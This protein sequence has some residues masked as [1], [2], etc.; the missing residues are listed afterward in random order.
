[1]TAGAPLRCSLSPK[2]TSADMP[3]A[4]SNGYFARFIRI[5]AVAAVLGGALVTLRGERRA[6]A[7]SG[8]EVSIADLTTF[9]PGVLGD[10]AL[11]G[12]YYEPFVA[13]FGGYQPDFGRDALLADWRDYL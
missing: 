1:M 12:V 2:G 11:E 3:R 4:R 8:G 6:R 5:A 7:C 9:N 10:P 13:G